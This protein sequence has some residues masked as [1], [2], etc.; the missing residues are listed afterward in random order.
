MNLIEFLSIFYSFC[1]DVNRIVVLQNGRCICE[2]TVG[3]TRYI[4]QV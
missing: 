3:D 4:R 1:T 2:K